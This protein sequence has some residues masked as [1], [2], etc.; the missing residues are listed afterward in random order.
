MACSRSRRTPRTSKGIGRCS[1]S[2]TVTFDNATSPLP[3]GTIDVPIQ[4]GTASGTLTNQ[5]WVLAQPGRNIPFDGSTIGAIVDGASLPNVATYG[6]PRPDVAAYF[7]SPTYANANGP[8]AQFSIDTTQIADGLHTIVWYAVDNLGVPQGIG[9]RYFTV[10]NGAASQV[11]APSSVQARSAAAVRALPRAGAFVW[12]RQGFT[13]R[14]WSLQWSGAKTPEIRQRPGERLAV[15]LDTWWWSKGCGPYAGYLMNGDVAGPLP[16]GASLD[17]EQG[18]FSWVPPAEFRG[19]F[20]LV[21][22]RRACTGREERIP[23]RV[24]IEPR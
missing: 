20:D 24:R 6:L 10:S 3:F 22:V 9:S 1:D 2:K 17:A 5:G 15:T 23:L 12:N 4:G 7:A 14:P 16:P 13:D 11:A 19:T 21:F 8:G 18:V